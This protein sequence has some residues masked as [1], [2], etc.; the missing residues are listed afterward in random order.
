MPLAQF[1]CFCGL[2]LGLGAAANAFSRRGN[3]PGEYT[4]ACACGLH[5]RLFLTRPHPAT[6]G[7][8]PDCPWCVGQVQ[9]TSRICARH[10]KELR[11][12]INSIDWSQQPPR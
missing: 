3:I 12:E 6:P 9:G 2:T 1:Q 7:P 8:Q 4:A 11:E 10:E 5:W